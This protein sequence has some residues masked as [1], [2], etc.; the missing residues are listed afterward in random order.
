MKI[1]DIT[2]DATLAMKFGYILVTLT[3]VATA[4]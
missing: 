2:I 3:D 4:F 1:I